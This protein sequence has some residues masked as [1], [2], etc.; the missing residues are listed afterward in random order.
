MAEKTRNL[1]ETL[2]V[3]Y[4]GGTVMG[5]S[6]RR[7]CHARYHINSNIEY[8]ARKY[9]VDIARAKR[10]GGRVFPDPELEIN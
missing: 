7:I 5:L 6:V 1:G 10:T 3:A 9:N 2:K 8:L 4:R